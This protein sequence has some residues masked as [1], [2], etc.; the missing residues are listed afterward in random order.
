MPRA[1]EIG[2]NYPYLKRQRGK[3]PWKNPATSSLRAGIN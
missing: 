2:Q 3:L 1:L